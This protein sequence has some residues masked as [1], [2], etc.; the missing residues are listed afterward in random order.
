[1]LACG[2]LVLGLLAAMSLGIIEWSENWRFARGIALTLVVF[3]PTLAMTLG[4]RK[5]R[6]LRPWR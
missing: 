4:R 5:A 6:R 1:M 3:I 2:L